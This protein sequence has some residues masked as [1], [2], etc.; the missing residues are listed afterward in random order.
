MP[1]LLFLI[2]F[3]PWWITGGRRPTPTWLLNEFFIVFSALSQ[4]I[5]AYNF[6]VYLITGKLF[7]SDL[8]QLFCRCPSGSCSCSSSW[9]SSA[10]AA[11]AVPI[12]A[13]DNDA[14]VARRAKT[15]TTAV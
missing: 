9:F 15:D 13:V 14:E 3:V 10:S 4:L 5:Y 1:G 7:R 2:W 12:A 11:V 6:Y 8:K